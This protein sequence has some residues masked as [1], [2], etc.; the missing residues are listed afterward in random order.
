M[1]SSYGHYSKKNIL[2]FYD[3][4]KQFIHDI[5]LTDEVYEKDYEDVRN[6]RFKSAKLAIENEVRFYFVLQEPA[7]NVIP[8]SSCAETHAFYSYFSGM[9]CT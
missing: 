6:K 3:L 2:S 7:P 8:I 1:Y 9:S 4:G 5:H